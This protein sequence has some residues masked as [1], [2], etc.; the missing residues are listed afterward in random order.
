MVRDAIAAGF[1][2]VVILSGGLDPLAARL[3]QEFPS[4][5]WF[6]IDHSNTIAPKRVVLEQSNQWNSNFTLVGVNFADPT[7]RWEEMLTKSPHFQPEADTIY[8]AEG[9]PNY[10]EEEDVDRIFDFVANNNTMSRRRII[11]T[12]LYQGPNGY[13]GPPQPQ[14]LFSQILREI[15]LDRFL[16]NSGET[17]KWAPQSDASLAE[18]LN[19][20]GF[21]F[22][23]SE[24][25]SLFTDFVLDRYPKINPKKLVVAKNEQVGI[26]DIGPS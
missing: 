12:Y 7:Q 11:F 5:Q 9:L 2:Q 1:K 22:Q 17:N 24:G 4:V 18:K 6:E 3:H 25:A 21:R 13:I 14:G 26:A 19:K 20:M 23:S 10:L 16:K 15:F 8:L